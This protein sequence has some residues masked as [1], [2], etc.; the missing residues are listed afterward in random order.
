MFKRWDKTLDLSDVW[1]NGNVPDEEIPNLGKEIAKRLRC[2]YSAK[3]FSEDYE[4]VEIVESFDN[5]ITVEE[6][7]SD[8]DCSIEW[9]TEEFN[10]A[11]ENLYDWADYNKRLCIVLN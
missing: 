3:A 1:D 10:L 11:M 5:I 4:L 8:N 2:M 9:I 7:L 6:A